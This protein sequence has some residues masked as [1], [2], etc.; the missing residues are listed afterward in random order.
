ME[1]RLTAEW[2]G[3]ALLVAVVIG[4]G[5]MGDRLASGNMAVALLGNTLATGAA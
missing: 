4:S 1:R 2:L 3:S 5:I